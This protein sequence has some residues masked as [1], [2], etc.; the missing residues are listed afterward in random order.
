MRQRFADAVAKMPTAFYKNPP[1]PSL[2]R[3]PAR[4]VGRAVRVSPAR[5]ARRCSRA[6]PASQGSR[7]RPYL[8]LR[9]AAMVFAAVTHPAHRTAVDRRSGRNDS[10]CPGYGNEGQSRASVTPSGGPR[11]RRG[12]RWC[13]PPGGGKDL[14]VRLGM[15]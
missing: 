6:L 4:K 15:D 3:L 10:S 13:H 9:S 7:T 11:P 5:R 14:Y 12:W 8:F 1:S 2:P